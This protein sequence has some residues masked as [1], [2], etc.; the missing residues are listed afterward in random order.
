VGSGDSAG[1]V[2]AVEADGC[3]SGTCKQLGNI[4]F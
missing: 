1:G 3:E 2:D 4:C